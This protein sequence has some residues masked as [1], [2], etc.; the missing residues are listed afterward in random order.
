[1][2]NVGRRV[3]RRLDARFGPDRYQVR[4]RVPEPALAHSS[5]RAD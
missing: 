4:M 2:Q 1:M 5:A 3:A